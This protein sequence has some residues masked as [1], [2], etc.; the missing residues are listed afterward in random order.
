MKKLLCAAALGFFSM[1][2]KAAPGDT[3]WVQ[4]HY[5]KWLDYYN[6]FDTTV[7]FPDGTTKYRKIIMVF[8]LGKYACPG[9][10]TYCSDWDYTVQTFL[11]NKRGDSLELGRLIT[12]YGKGS[13][14][15]S[16]VTW[17]QPYYFDVTDFAPALVDSNTIR[18]L[19]SGYSGGFTADIRFAMIEGTPERNVL[20]VQKLW[21]GSFAYGSTTDPIDNHFPAKTLNPP[22]GTDKARLAFNVTGHGAD[23]NYCSEF[24]SKYYRV[25]K[26]STMLAEKQI[27]RDN[28]GFNNLYPQSGTWVYDRGNWCPGAQVYTIYHDIAAA[29]TSPFDLAIN[30][31]PYSSSGSASYTTYATAIFY[32]PMNKT[33]DASL[34]DIIA[35]SDDPN[36]FRANVRTG[37]TTIRLRNSGSTAISSVTFEYGVTGSPL[38]TYTWAGSLAAQQDT[39]I[40]LPFVNS[41]LSA[42]GTTLPYEVNILS[43]N[44]GA[45]GDATNNR[46]TNTFTPAPE[47]PTYF[48]VNFQ[49]NASTVGATSETSWQITDMASNVVVAS[50]TGA[51]AS[52]LYN[53]TVRL[54]TG[55]YKLSVIDAGCD[56]LSFWANPSAGSGFFRIK[57]TPFTTQAVGGYY[58]GDFGCG[59]DQ[60]FRVG[61]PTA[62]KEL[63]SG[64]ASGTMSVYPNPASARISVSLDLT[65]AVNGTLSVCDYTG[66]V[67]NSRPVNQPNTELDASGLTNGMYFVNYVPAENGA[68]KLQAKVVILR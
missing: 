30:F 5:G 9:T 44:G 20:A 40:D 55:V 29:G 65:G 43:V 14:M 12:P 46:F 17:N 42:T 60:Y 21:A 45:D 4:A 22:A 15:G 39:V 25:M 32:G 16:T 27:W 63:M 34:E 57:P 6:N 52:T 56:G 59:F 58:G 33:L 68:Q 36:H 67:V 10:P 13:R 48:V 50:R 7:K 37:Y 19:Y 18:I 61:V 53:D 62:V 26:N 2:A 28:C 1:V 66:R 31:E 35:P 24:C 64:A 54:G 41:L 8:T 49:T 47:W 38:R 3:T 51:A 11:M 23:P